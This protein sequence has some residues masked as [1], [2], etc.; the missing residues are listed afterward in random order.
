MNYWLSP[1]GKVYKS[2]EIGCHYR[3]AVD[4]IME[5]HEHLLEQSLLKDFGE[6]MY[7]GLNAVE[8]LENLGYIRYMDWDKPRWII[9]GQ[10]PTRIQIKKMFELT[11]F[12]YESN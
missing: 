5:K 6:K 8:D 2:D 3:M 4:I 11:N 10:K 12:I 7:N 1:S 9:Y